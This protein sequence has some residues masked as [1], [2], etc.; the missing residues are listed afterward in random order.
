MKIDNKRGERLL[1][2]AMACHNAGRDFRTER[3]RN[4][5]YAYGRQ[6]NDVIEADGVRMTEE[7]YIYSQ[8]NIP[9]KNN[10]I[11]RLV[12]NVLGIFRTRLQEQMKTWRETD[13]TPFKPSRWSE[14]NPHKS[15][16]M[17]ISLSPITV[18]SCF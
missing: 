16:L 8:G 18:S 7:E 2:L 5:D 15:L 6:W 17:K 12:R 10:L 1:S 14:G 9:L 13:P 3:R 4:K 11:R